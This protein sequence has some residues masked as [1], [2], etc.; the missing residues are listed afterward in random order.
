MNKAI[1][2]RDPPLLYRTIFEYWEQLWIAAATI[3]TLLSIAAVIMCTRRLMK[4]H[5]HHPVPVNDIPMTKQ[6]LVARN[7]TVC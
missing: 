1:D 5:D 3:T 6:F 4:R 2:I 7:N